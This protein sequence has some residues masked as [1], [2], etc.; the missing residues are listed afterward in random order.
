MSFCYFQ[1]VIGEDKLYLLH[2]NRIELLQ[3]CC[4]STSRFVCK[5]YTNILVMKFKLILLIS[6]VVC[7]F[8]SLCCIFVWLLL[9][10]HFD[11]PALLTFFLN[12]RPILVPT[13]IDFV[14]VL[15]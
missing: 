13:I 1:T 9:L 5:I 3:V 6:G 14:G 8:V 12:L 4:V 2:R 15:S 11:S 7:C 10:F